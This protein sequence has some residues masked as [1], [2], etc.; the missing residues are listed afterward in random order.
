MDKI[1]RPAD[2][3]GNV[4]VGEVL[5]NLLAFADDLVLLMDD[6]NHLQEGI[7]RLN[8]ACEEFGMKINVSKT[9]VMHVGKNRKEV[10]CELNDQVLEQVSQ[11]KYLGTM[12]CEDGKLVKEID[13]RRKNGNAVASQLRSHV[14]NKKEL[15]ADTKLS[16]HRSIFR[17][18]I[19]YGSESWEDC[20]Y[21]VHDLEV[22]DMN[23]FRR[24]ARVNRRNQWDDHIRNCDIREIV[25]VTS[26]E[27]AFA[28]VWAC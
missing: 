17:P 4:E 3:Q 27:E 25:G 14:F 8:V 1:I 11:F 23:V 26:V 2:V 28:L 18:T 13:H 16:I 22:A 21:L 12:F 6:V 19:L 20:G 15:S 9:K 24:I 5:Y 10:V 7:N